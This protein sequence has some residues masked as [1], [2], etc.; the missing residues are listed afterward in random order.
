MIVHI[1][2]VSCVTRNMADPLG[3]YRISWYCGTGIARRSRT[4]PKPKN[5]KMYKLCSMQ[6][7]YVYFLYILFTHSFQY[8]LHTIFISSVSFFAIVCH[9]TGLMLGLRPVS[10][11]RRYC[12]SHW[13]GASQ[14]SDLHYMLYFDRTVRC[15][16]SRKMWY[17]SGRTLRVDSASWWQ[18]RNSCS[19]V[20]RW[21][22]STA[23]GRAEGIWCCVCTQ[24]KWSWRILPR[25]MCVFTLILIILMFE[26]LEEWWICMFAYIVLQCCYDNFCLNAHTVVGL[27]TQTPLITLVWNNMCLLPWIDHL[28]PVCWPT[29]GEFSLK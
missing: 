19:I 2:T 25:C 17:Q 28:P 26:C 27:F 5:C 18:G 16:K 14:E 24:K 22:H 8:F 21:R 9:A 15:Y 4:I 3:Q 13:L 23:V 1:H 11:R 12:V 6:H 20:S 29:F 7:T 10:E